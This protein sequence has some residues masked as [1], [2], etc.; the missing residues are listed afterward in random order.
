MDS[1]IIFVFVNLLFFR[2]YSA[3]IC[4]AFSGRNNFATNKLFPNFLDTFGFHGTFWI[5][6][7]VMVIQIIYTFFS[8]VENKGES[9]TKSEDKMISANVKQPKKKASI[10]GAIENPAFEVT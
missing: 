2:S 1:Q 9:L 5:Y 8:L 4:V 3:G 10:E 6:S 7:G